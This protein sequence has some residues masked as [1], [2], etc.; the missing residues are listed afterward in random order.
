MDNVPIERQRQ[1]FP[2]EAFNSNGFDPKGDEPLP[3][4][5]GLLLQKLLNTE[6]VP[7]EIKT[8]FW[9]IF[10]DDVTLGFSDVE[11][12]KD[13]LLVF[14]ILKLHTKFSKPY[15][16][17]NWNEAH[18][19]M[20]VRHALDFRLDRALGAT[21]VGVLNERSAEISQFSELRHISEDKSIQGTTGGFMGK[22]RKVFR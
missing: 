21:K 1:D 11:R 8:E 2:I 20:I 14:E 3:Q 22:I 7:K 16:Q 17:Y 19:S 12:K 15:F 9:N 10:S 4:E 5:Q 13:K 6:V 18:K